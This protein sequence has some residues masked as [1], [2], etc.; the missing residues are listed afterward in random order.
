MPTIVTVHGTFASGEAAGAQWWQQGSRC[1]DALREL[2]VPDRGALS[3][4]PVI[5]SGENSEVARREG[6][7]GLLHTFK[8]LE[9]ADEPYIAIGHS[10]GGSVIAFALQL[11]AKEGLD[12]PRLKRWITVGTPFIA[13][14]KKRWLYSRGDVF[15]KGI[16][17]LALMIVLAVAARNIL[18]GAALGDIWSVL[19]AAVGTVA[20]LAAITY[21]I[22]LYAEGDS[23][24]WALLAPETQAAVAGRFS[25]RWTAYW[26]PAD[27]AVLGLHHAHTMQSRLFP[28]DFATHFYLAA[29]IPGLPLLAFLMAV[30]GID[31]RVADLLRLTAPHE[32]AMAAYASRDIL[33]LPD[34]YATAGELGSGNLL[35][36]TI[37]TILAVPVL[38]ARFIRW[39]G[40]ETP[41]VMGVLMV[42]A[43]VGY[44]YLAK[45]V[46]HL[47]SIPTS[48]A[49]NAVTLAQVRTM[50]DGADVGAERAVGC[51]VHPPWHGAGPGSRSDSQPEPLPREIADEITAI[52][53]HAAVT[54]LPKFRA[55]LGELALSEKLDDLRARFAAYL[56]WEELI[57]TAYFNSPRFMTLLADTCAATDGF[58]RRRRSRSRSA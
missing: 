9:Q 29:L 19:T 35:D 53:D 5:W 6:A 52:S 31:G 14:E 58:A 1:E 26:H 25:D 18:L 15:V 41:H 13:F 7:R 20:G 54:A 10:H 40:A 12:M 34:W 23:P 11:A 27:E 30:T 33:N 55:A 28:P 49:L 8:E 50:V 22:A 46:A 39:L 21:L 36:R 38:A 4:H 47:L 45:S 16:Y 37:M 56:T 17:V 2:L 3:W 32:A 57:H 48:W 42:G 44:V 51:A 24:D 43:A